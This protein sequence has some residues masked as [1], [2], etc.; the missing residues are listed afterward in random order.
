VLVVRVDGK[1]VLDGCYSGIAWSKGEGPTAFR[2]KGKLA[3]LW[4]DS[5]KIGDWFSIGANGSEIEVI[6]GAGW[7][8]AF[9]AD[10]CVEEEGV[11]YSGEQRPLFKIEGYQKAMSTIQAALS[12]PE[13]PAA[14]TLDGP[15]FK[16]SR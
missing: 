15:T 1:L 13:S 14:L 16:M 10:L 7:G 4:S 8:G 5:R 3:P 2:A 11:T 12:R 6:L 9:G